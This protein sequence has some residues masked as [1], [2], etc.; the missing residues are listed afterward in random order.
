MTHEQ[1]FKKAPFE[2]FLSICIGDCIGEITAIEKK[3]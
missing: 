2:V 1:Q 3:M